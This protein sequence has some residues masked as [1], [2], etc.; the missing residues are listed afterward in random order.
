ML[1]EMDGFN[2]ADSQVLVIGATNVKHVLDP[3]L[4]R[5]GRFDRVIPMGLPSRQSRL[6]I[7]QVNFLFCGPS[8]SS[9]PRV[10]FFL[11]LAGSLVWG[12]PPAA[13]ASP[14]SGP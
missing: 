14:A 5:P 10:F 6:R 13:F 3:A 1:V 12:A 7:L 9:R 8:P 2:S 4:L 11:F